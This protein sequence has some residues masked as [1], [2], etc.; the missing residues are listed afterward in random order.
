MTATGSPARRV[1]GFILRV[2]DLIKPWKTSIGTV[3]HVYLYFIPD[4]ALLVFQVLLGDVESA[5]AVC[6]SP[7]HGLQFVRGHR[8]KVVG[9]IKTRGPVQDSAIR[10]HQLD[11]LHFAQVL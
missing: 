7:Q 10:L 4:D 8:F 11:E 1:P 6:L 3:Q 2:E 5:H 9:E